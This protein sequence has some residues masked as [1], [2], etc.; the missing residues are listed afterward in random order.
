M[1]ICRIDGNAIATIHHPT[2]R[3]WRQLICQPLDALGTPVG[4]PLLSMDKLGAGVK[5]LVLV[6]SD[7]KS[8]RDAV[9]TEFT[10]LRY[11][12]IAILDELPEVKAS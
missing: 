7:G 11:M 10:P 8:I 4:K 1:L 6:T 3:G 12:T 5:D 2:L 9:G